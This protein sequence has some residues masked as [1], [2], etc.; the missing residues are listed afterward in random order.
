MRPSPSSDL[1]TAGHDDDN[2]ID[3]I[4]ETVR[5]DSEGCQ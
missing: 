2:D 1:V 3:E 4:I 5:D